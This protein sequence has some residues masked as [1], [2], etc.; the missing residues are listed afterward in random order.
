[1]SDAATPPRAARLPPPLAFALAFLAGLLLQRLLPLPR[2]PADL[3][4]VLALAA[5]PALVAGTA[6]AL[7]GFASFLARRTTLIPHHDASQLVTSGPYALTRNPMYLGLTLVY[8]GL[9]MLLGAPGPVIL[10]P[11]PVLFVHRHVIPFEEARLSALFGEAYAHY[12]TRVGRWVR[13]H[14]R[15]RPPET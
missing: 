10:L 3:R 11:L 14:G 4:H 15:S 1:M 7:A 6:L 13:W 9:A 12:R 2:V 8:L 5:I